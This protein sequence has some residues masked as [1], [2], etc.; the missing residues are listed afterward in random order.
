MENL[1]LYK[2]IGFGILTILLILCTVIAILTYL[3]RDSNTT[4]H[5]FMLAIQ[6]HLEI[7]V[8]LIVI[9][10]TFGFVW[11]S[12]AIGEAEK[13]KKDNRKILE[14]V[15]L[16]LNN[17]EKQIIDF[18][19]KQEGNTSQ[20]EISRLPNMGRVKA[21]RSLRKMEEKRLVDIVSH[22]K[23]RKVSLKENIYQLLAEK[24]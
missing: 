11:S 20:A 1:R 13:Q 15:L 10:I 7:M 21:Y 19:I 5:L 12:I 18:L 3:G 9:S 22:G 4:S 2:N 23:V 17:E 8:L 24:I 16:F 14:I 6:H